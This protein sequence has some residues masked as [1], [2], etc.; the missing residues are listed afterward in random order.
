MVTL[1]ASTLLRALLVEGS[2]TLGSHVFSSSCSEPG[3]ITLCFL[4]V[5]VTKLVWSLSTSS[6]VLVCLWLLVLSCVL[7]HKNLLPSFV[8]ALG[9]RC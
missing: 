4:D 8:F 6:V 3:Q 5:A 7:A 9:I 2:P 1:A